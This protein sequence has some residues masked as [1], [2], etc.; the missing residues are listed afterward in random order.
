[1]TDYEGSTSTAARESLLAWGRDVVEERPAGS[2]DAMLARAVLAIAG[3]GPYRTAVYP[4]A[5]AMSC[6]PLWVSEPFENPGEAMD[7]AISYL[8][9]GAPE[10][11]EIEGVPGTWGKMRKVVENGVHIANVMLEPDG[12][13]YR[14]RAAAAR[15]CVEAMIGRNHK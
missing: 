3:V 14:E 10:V 1:M 7:A 9:N 8:L 15:S 12:V 13:G 4:T 2:Y 11:L 5:K 6:A